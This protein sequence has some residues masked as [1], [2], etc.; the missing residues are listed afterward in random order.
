MRLVDTHCHLDFDQLSDNLDEHIREA[1]RYGITQF[2]VPG[3]TLTQSKALLDFKRRVPECRIGFGLHPYFLDLGSEGDME[4]LWIRAQQ[5]R[6]HLSAVGEC[7]I[8]AQCDHL[9]L[10]QKLFLEHIKLANTLAL[11]LIV[12]HR[13]SHHLIAQAFKSVKPQF[14]GVIHAFSGSIQQ[15]QYYIERGFKLGIGGTITYPRA[16]KTHAVVKALPLS[17]FVLETD[18][19]SMPLNG[20]Q[21]QPNLPKRLHQ[22]FEHFCQLRS[23]PKQMIAEQ[24]YSSSCALFSI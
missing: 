6:G 17:S 1:A 21:G 13:Q 10:Q 3:I 12:H 2:V 18:A 8:D 24:L 4:E 22:V 14:G 23:E 19:P 7:G 15:A 9:A 5:H 11:P 20:F 16:Q